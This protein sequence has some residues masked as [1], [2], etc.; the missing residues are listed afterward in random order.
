MSQPIKV[1]GSVHVGWISVKAGPQYQACSMHDSPQQ[2]DL[3]KAGEVCQ[4]VWH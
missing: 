1:N 4:G 2:E 3:R